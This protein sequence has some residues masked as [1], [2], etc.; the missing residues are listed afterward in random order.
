MGLCELVKHLKRASYIKSAEVEM[1]MLR[2]DRALYVPSRYGMYAYSDTPLEIGFGQTISAPHM[3]AIMCELLELEPGLKILEVGAGSGYHAAI[4][5][6]IVGEDGSVSS[7]DRIS[8]LIEMA[9]ENLEKSGIKNVKFFLGDG[10]LGLEGE[11]PFDRILVTCGSPLIPAPLKKQL[12]DGGVMVIPVGDRYFQDLMVIRKIENG[13]EMRNW[14][15]VV[16]VPLI[17]EGGFGP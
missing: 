2:V 5:G 3:V 14:G 8:E 12:L 6:E 9:R 10:S 7:I 11:G 16:F 17:G 15:G 13:Y 1:A 4:L